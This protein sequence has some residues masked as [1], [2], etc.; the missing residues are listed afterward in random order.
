MLATER[1]FFALL[2]PPAIQAE[3]GRL[4]AW[5]ERRCGGRAVAPHN[6]HLT[7][8]FL[9]ELAPGQVEAVRRAPAGLRVAPFEV[10]LDRI[11]YWP[12]PR[13]Y[14]AVSAGPLPAAAALAAALRQ[15]VRDVVAVPARPFVAHVTLLRRPRRLQELPMPPIAWTATEFCLMS[16]RRV[17]GERHYVPVESWPCA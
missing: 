1:L 15:A 17:D 14:C 6:I 5:C 4:A 3:L 13:L 10:T 9:G 16:A 11:E 12:G 2:P 7:L 8:L